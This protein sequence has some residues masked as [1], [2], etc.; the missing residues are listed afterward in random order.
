MTAG[1]RGGVGGLRKGGRKEKA[2]AAAAKCDD[3]R[4][5]QNKTRAAA[6]HVRRSQ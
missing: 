3:Q 5:P 1:E 4:S 6:T 2:K